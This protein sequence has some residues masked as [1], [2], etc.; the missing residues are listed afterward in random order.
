MGTDLQKNKPAGRPSVDARGVPVKIRVRT[1]WSLRSISLGV[2][3]IF[4][5]IGTGDDPVEVVD[6]V[7]IG[8]FG[9]TG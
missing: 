3:G 1:F 7:E 5:P 2:K 8:Q 9:T 4:L 6:P